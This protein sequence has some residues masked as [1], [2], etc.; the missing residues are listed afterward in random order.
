MSNLGLPAPKP[1][2][3]TEGNEHWDKDYAQYPYFL[4]GDS[5]F[6]LTKYMMKLC[7]QNKSLNAEQRIFNYRLSRLR[8]I[9]EN[10]FGMA[11]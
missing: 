6:S 3:V 5:A 2:P 7:D 8:R 9:S 1:L 11:R 10:A 4:V